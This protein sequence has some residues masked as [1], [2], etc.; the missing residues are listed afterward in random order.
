MGL[1]TKIKID[2]K[3]VVQLHGET[4]NLSGDTIIADNGSLTYASHPTFTNDVQIVDKKYVDDNIN[5]V[6]NIYNLS[7]PATITL[8]GIIEGTVLTGKTSNEILEELLVPYL[9]PSFSTFSNN[10]S[11]IVEVGC[12]ISGSKQFNWSFSHPENV[13]LNSV[14]ICDITGNVIIASNLG[15]S[16]QSVLIADVSFDICG[17]VYEWCAIGQNTKDI[18]FSSNKYTVTSYL[19]YFWGKCTCPGPTG[20][21]RPIPNASMITNGQKVLNDSS[22]SITINFNS[23]DNDYIWFAIP[24]SVSNKTCW[25][26][27]ALNNGKI[28]GSIIPGGNLFPNPELVTNVS[29]TCWNGVSYNVYISNYQTTLNSVTIS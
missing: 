24:S 9:A 4:L 15:T 1:N 25:F 21:N 13:K 27:N 14:C 28:G 23:T 6:S 12:N 26:V 19:P 29:T 20:S 17:Q 3:H 16:P 2:D 11:S 10:V 8:G 22:N 5:S 7:S 18:S